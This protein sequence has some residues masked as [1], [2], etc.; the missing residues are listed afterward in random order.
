MFR[1]A[2]KMIDNIGGTIIAEEYTPAGERDFAPIIRKISQSG[3]NILLF[4]LPGADGITFIRQAEEFGLLD[5]I[6]IAFLGFS[7][8][9]LGAFGKNKGENM[10]T[11]VP[12][13][14]SDLNPKVVDFV[15]RVRDQHGP[16]TGVS[17]YVFSHYNSLIA[18]KKGL[19][20][21]GEISRE[22]A[23]DGME[24]LSFETATG[25]ATISPSDHHISMN[26]FIA[27]TQNGS[28]Q[29]IKPLGMIEPDSG[30]NNL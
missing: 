29:V 21:A 24:G 13:V 1:A 23:I 11:G 10:I 27:M 28:L 12:F 26:M 2:R 15:S 8:T 6:R 25:N 17:H 30:C 16:E 22:S 7:E 9:Y 20:R 18:L 3:A 19:E 14:A 5:E 4:A